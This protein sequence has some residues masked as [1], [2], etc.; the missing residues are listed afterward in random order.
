MGKLFLLLIVIG[1]VVLYSRRR[2]RKRNEA[3]A[4]GRAVLAKNLAVA[5]K[6][7]DLHAEQPESPLPSGR[8]VVLGPPEGSPERD[9]LIKEA[10]DKALEFQTANTKVVNLRQRPKDPEVIVARHELRQ[11][12]ANDAA[13]SDAA[14][15]A[16]IAGAILVADELGL[17]P[18]H[19]LP[20]HD[21]PTT[22]EEQTD[23]PSAE[24]AGDDSSTGSDD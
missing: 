24:T 15:A 8:D 14:T 9:A 10:M 21:E 11:K 18:V 1:G 4:K 13:N 2:N 16:G 20:I 3:A 23:D 12:Q 6:P 7:D 19:V 22:T 17:L 5:A